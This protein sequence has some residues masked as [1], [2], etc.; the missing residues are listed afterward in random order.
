MRH[1]I[2]G[3]EFSKDD[4]AFKIELPITLD[5]LTPIMKWDDEAYCANDHLLTPAQIHAIEIVSGVNI[6]KNFDL[7]LTC[8][9]SN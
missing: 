2:T 4:I 8:E 1:F 3:F 7:Y 5:D 6:P 9:R